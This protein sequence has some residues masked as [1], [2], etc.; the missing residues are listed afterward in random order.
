MGLVA[1]RHVGSSQ[2][3]AWTRVPCIGRWILNHWAT[4]EVL[5]LWFL[6]WHVNCLEVCLISNIGTFLN[7]LLLLFSLTFW[8]SKDIICKISI[9]LKFVEIYFKTYHTCGTSLAVQWL[10]FCTSTA[11]GVG[12]IPG[13]V[14]RSH[15]THCM[16]KKKKKAYH[17]LTLVSVHLKWMC[18]LQLLGVGS[19]SSVSYWEKSWH[20]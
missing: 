9:F 12:S 13:R 5:P 19:S 16:A 15:V 1:P 18:V 10:R 17:T 11:G 3:R 14:I 20:V 7:I 2:T 8:M 4:R 6:P